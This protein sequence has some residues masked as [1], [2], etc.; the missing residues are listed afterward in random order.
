MEADTNNNA[1]A[2]LERLEARKRRLYIVALGCGVVIILLSW[3]FR[4]PADDAFLTYLYPVFAGLLGGLILVLWFDLLSLPR[5]E[6][7]IML[8]AGSL[9]LGRLGWHH[10]VSGP[11]DQQLLVLVGGHYWAVGALIVGAFVMLDRRRG[12]LAGALILLVSALL[13]ITGA[14]PEIQRGEASAEALLYLV[15]VHVF[16]LLLLV[17]VTAVAGLR[18]RLHHALVRAEMLDHWARTDMLTGLAN[19][20]AAD[21]Y[22]Q[23]EMAAARRYQRPLSVMITDLDHFKRINDTYGHNAGDTVIREAARRFTAVTRETDLVARWGGEEFLI[24]A[25][26]T[27]LD[28]AAHLAERCRTALAETGIDDI[29]VTATFGVTRF[30]ADDGLDSLVGRADRQLYCGKAEGRN[31]VVADEAPEAAAPPY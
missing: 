22:L 2:E 1:H 8:V 7:L 25:P 4:T 20:R 28:E 13:A 6:I 27:D 17:L 26:E 14:G 9:V 15:R 24:I 11:I 19:R 12:L 3:A 30:R 29:R 18:D 31:R 23:R 16:L 21:A 5:A 10:H